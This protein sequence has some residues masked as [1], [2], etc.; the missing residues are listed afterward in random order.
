MNSITIVNRE[1][2]VLLLGVAMAVGPGCKKF[3]TVPAPITST[4]AANVYSTDATAAAVMTGLYARMMNTPISQSGFTSISLFTALSADEMTVYNYNT[5]I[6]GQYPPYYLNALTAV[7]HAEPYIWS[8][9]YPYV[10]ITNAAIEGL[11]GSK[12]LTPSVK[13]QLLGEAKFIRALCFFYLVNLYGDVPL[14]LTTDYNVTRILPRTPE[15]DVYTQVIADLTEAQDLMSA[16]FLRADRIT[17]YPANAAERIHPTRWAAAALLARVYLYTGDYPKAEGEATQVIDNTTMFSLTGLTDV[18]KKNSAEAIWQMQPTITFAPNAS[19]EPILYVLPS[20][21]P[22]TSGQYPVYLSDTL[23]NSFEQG[24]NRKTAWTDSVSVN[25][26]TYY[27]PYKYRN[28]A[29]TGAVT[30][31][32]MV[33]RLAEQYLIR[34]EARAQQGN[35]SGA[36]A[37]LN[38]IRSRAGLGAS[39]AATQADILSAILHERQVELFT[40]WG[41]RWLDLKRTGTIDAVMT[42]ISPIKGGSWISSKQLYPVPQSEI[43]QDPMLVQNAGY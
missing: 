15:K 2:R 10:F 1:I 36:L 16:N 24:D 7:N 37:D 31:Y 35:L 34:A 25:G 3:I 4:N 21:G 33:L 28:N 12:T 43:N 17:A 13:Q 14:P 11:N 6:T 38:V 42:G 40:E 41:H 39:M 27:Y 22:N 23:V 8:L 19:G 5:Q 30:E 26:T 32:E 20:G 18:F 29:T 9:I